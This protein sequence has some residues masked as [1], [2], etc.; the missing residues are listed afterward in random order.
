[1]ISPDSGIARLKSS[2]QDQPVHTHYYYEVRVLVRCNVSTVARESTNVADGAHLGASDPVPLIGERA[3]RMGRALRG[4]TVLTHL[5]L[6]VTVNS[7][8]LANTEGIA[9]FIAVSRSLDDLMLLLDVPYNHV[10]AGEEARNA[11]ILDRF[12]LAAA[13]NGHLSRLSISNAFGALP[14]ANCLHANR[15]TL[16]QLVLS[17]RGDADGVVITPE[18]NAAANVVADAFGSLTSLDYICINDQNDKRFVLP[19]LSRL[20]DHPSLR[21]LSVEGMRG[22][23]RDVNEERLSSTPLERLG[24]DVRNNDSY[25]SAKVIFIGLHGQRANLST[26]DLTDICPESD[27]GA[28]V[29]AVMLRHNTTVETLNA[30]LSVVFDSLRLRDDWY[31]YESTGDSKAEHRKR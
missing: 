31:L 22:E 29:F 2:I 14:L 26:L 3:F 24:F 30:D 10:G 9:T 21:E 12:L 19:I 8:S 15:T 25:E 20:V 4:N 5:S 1:L 27:E 7:L 13:L 6:H 17:F 23:A 18:M 28:D 11:P 16:E